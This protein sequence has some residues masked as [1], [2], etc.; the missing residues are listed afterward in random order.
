[1]NFLALRRPRS[2]S[3]PA[4]YPQGSRARSWCCHFPQLARL[5]AY[6]PI[7]PSHITCMTSG[8]QSAG[9]RCVLARNST[10]LPSLLQTSGL[11]LTNR[12]QAHH[13]HRGHTCCR[14]GQCMRDAGVADARGPQL[15]RKGT[16]PATV[17]VSPCPGAPAST[18]TPLLSPPSCGTTVLALLCRSPHRGHGQVQALVRL[19]SCRRDVPPFPGTTHAAAAA[20]PPRMT[21]SRA[22][23]DTPGMCCRHQERL[24]PTAA[25]RLRRST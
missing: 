4:S 12:P 14:Y 16:S 3:R 8:A 11:G 5:P 2:A 20:Q 18:P 10:I 15:A 17:S 13:S 7:P 6:W 19:R 22:T 23:V 25:R 21:C 1:M 9:C 24:L